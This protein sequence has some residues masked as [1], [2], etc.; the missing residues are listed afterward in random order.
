MSSPAGSSR[1][2]L[3]GLVA[4]SIVVLIG[5]AVWAIMGP[6]QRPIAPAVVNPQIPGAPSTTTEISAADAK[7]AEQITDEIEPLLASKQFDQVARLAQAAIDRFPQHQRAHLLAAQA[8]IGLK[9]NAK[10]YD[11]LKAALA[12]GPEN[13]EIQT[14]AGTMASQVRLDAQAIEHFTRATL[15]A[16]DNPTPFM[17]LGAMY[18]REPATASPTPGTEASGETKA[19]LNFRKASMLDPAL[20]TPYAAMAEISLRQNN[21][22]GAMTHIQKARELEPDRVA[23]RQLEARILKR[24]NRPQKAIDLLINLPPADRYSDSIL[25]LL[26]DSH[27]MLRRFEQAAKLYEEAAQFAPQRSAE[28]LQQAKQFRERVGKPAEPATNPK[29]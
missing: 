7:L 29:P 22:T 11:H 2:L 23:W 12:I 27:A 8:A 19:L 17:L 9:N 4:L 26:A 16:P 13:A 6:K 14:M 18:M 15:L 1:N 24:D 25:P 28:Y 5:V 21:L 20:A 10:A 3:L